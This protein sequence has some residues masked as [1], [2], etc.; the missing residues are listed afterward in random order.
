MI[1]MENI[2]LI[3]CFII[4]FCHN[5]Q[6]FEIKNELQEEESQFSFNAN[7]MFARFESIVSEIFQMQVV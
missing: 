2:L 1:V 5:A 6:V 4:Y 7:W 3:F